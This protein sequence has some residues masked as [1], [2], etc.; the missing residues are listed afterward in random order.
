MD[1]NDNRKNVIKAKMSHGIGLMITL[2]VC[3]VLIYSFAGVLVRQYLFLLLNL[4]M[5]FYDI[6]RV[7]ID[8]SEETL[9]HQYLLTFPN[10]FEVFTDILEVLVCSSSRFL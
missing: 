3:E 2:K 8:S 4:Y 1:K 7:L 5:I 10:F 9:Y 6:P